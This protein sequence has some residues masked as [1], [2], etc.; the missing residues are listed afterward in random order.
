MILL[1]E[2][3][4]ILIQNLKELIYS[5]KY[6]ITQYRMLKTEKSLE[7]PESLN[8]GNW[9]TMTNRQLWGGHSETY[10]FETVITVP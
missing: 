6:P 4:G 7:H 5:R 10:Y 3:E 9:E 1:K 2:R 8:T